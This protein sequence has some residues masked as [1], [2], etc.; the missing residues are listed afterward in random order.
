MFSSF[1]QAK[2]QSAAAQVSLYSIYNCGKDDDIYNR[3][4]S[5]YI[6]KTHKVL[7]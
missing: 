5:C 3:E 7:E 4:L 2:D 1:S 6:I